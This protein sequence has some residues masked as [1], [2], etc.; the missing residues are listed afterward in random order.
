MTSFASITINGWR[1]FDAVSI[2]FHPRLTIITGSNGAGKS[3]ILNICAQHFAP[4]RPFLATPKRRKGGGFLFDPGLLAKSETAGS[5]TTF[6]D[7]EIEQEEE[8]E[9][10]EDQ[11]DPSLSDGFDAYKAATSRGR[12]GN[13]IP[14]GDFRYDNG[15][16]GTIGF[17]ENQSHSYGLQITNQ[18]QVLGVPISSHRALASYQP[19][20]GL[21]FQIISLAAA[22]QNYMSEYVTRSNGGQSQFSPMYRMKETLI[23]MAAFGE[24]NSH[25]ERIDELAAAFTDFGKVLRK[26]LP[27]EI[28]FQ[29]LSVRAPDII[30]KTRSGEF[31]VD[32]G[33]GGI[34]AVIEI[35]WQLFLYSRIQPS[36][37]ATLDEPENHLHP[38]MQ[39]S[40]LANLVDAFP[41]VQFVV[42]THSPFIV[43]AVENSRVYALRYTGKLGPNG[44]PDHK[45]RRVRS[46]ELDQVKKAG[47][48]SEILEEV[49]GVRVSIPEWASRQLNNIIADFEGVEVTTETLK[50]LRAKLAEAGFSDYYPEALANLVRHK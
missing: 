28:G 21:S 36:F 8:E 12:P 37:S 19:V 31:I 16:V 9:E 17:H 24:G 26:V 10:E 33:S 25:F 7:D 50:Q 34:T 41:Q 20:A 15:A 42:A 22:Y 32:A 29:R 23:A 39:R 4:A 2:D 38:S 35:T 11:I 45:T 30:L 48:A 43:S 47:S 49:L 44:F 46:V 40:I 13:F 27:K 1:Q 6:F 14:I 5:Y 18:Q 3:T